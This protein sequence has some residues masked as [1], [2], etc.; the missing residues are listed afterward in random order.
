[1]LFQERGMYGTSSPA[2]ETK[3][4]YSFNNLY[5]WVKPTALAI[6]KP[7]SFFPPLGKK[8]EVLAKEDGLFPNIQKQAGEERKPRIWK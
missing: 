5:K 7:W 2:S 8:K 3:D 6:S 1:M 4:L